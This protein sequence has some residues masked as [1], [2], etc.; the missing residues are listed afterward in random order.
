MTSWSSSPASSRRRDRH[1]AAAPSACSARS[2]PRCS[3]PRRAAPAPTTPMAPVIGEVTAV[4]DD[5]T[6]QVTFRVEASDNTGVIRATVLFTTPG[7]RGNVDRRAALTLPGRRVAGHGVSRSPPGR[8]RSTSS[9]RPSTAAATS[10]M[11]T[12]KGSYYRSVEV[13]PPTID[14]SGNDFDAPTGWYTGPVDVMVAPF[15]PGGDRRRH[16]ERHARRR[17][18]CASTEDG[19]YEIVAT[20][21]GAPTTS[22]VVRIDSSG[23][24][25]LDWTSG[26]PDR[27]SLV[28][29]DVS[30]VGTDD[31]IGVDVDPLLDE[32][33]P[34][35][36]AHDRGRRHHRDGD[37][38]R[39]R[40]DHGHR[41]RHRPSRA[42][43]PAGVDRG[44]G[45]RGRRRVTTGGGVRSAAHGVA[46]RSTWSCRAPPTTWSPASPPTRRRASTCARR[47]RPA[48]RRRRRRRTSRTMCDNDSNCTPSRPV[49]A[50]EGRQAGADRD[51]VVPA[52][53]RA[54][55]PARLRC[56]RTRCARTPAAGWPAVHRCRC[57]PST[58][59]P[60][61]VTVTGRDVAGNVTDRR[62]QLPRRP[63]VER[64]PAPHARPAADQPH[65]AE[66]HLP[67]ALLG[68]RRLAAHRPGP[69]RT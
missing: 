22:Q 62:R 35:D 33:G 2:G 48:R 34:G 31:G 25:G 61:T 59:G 23:A 17:R 32:R 66:R 4:L 41:R 1:A 3:T 65:P 30:V 55:H 63:A 43:E 36:A 5:A 24:Q 49:D 38:R 45:R 50:V 47:C 37:G 27:P 53:G 18:T 19:V 16:R 15:A 28:P 13:G 68:V 56:R 69:H 46:A 42:G 57:R 58:L 64:L 14:V 6:G 9:S 12:N 54:G 20:S 52:A 60:K 7:D 11:S 10:A 21:E 40:H 26:T 29:V 67:G 51:R 44:R 39:V 8:R